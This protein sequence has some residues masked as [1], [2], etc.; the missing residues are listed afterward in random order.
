MAATETPEAT[1]NDFEKRHEKQLGVGQFAKIQS[2][3]ILAPL[4][5]GAIGA[6]I[7]YVTLGK[8]LARMFPGLVRRAKDIDPLA[9]VVIEQTTN[10]RKAV[11]PNA[12]DLINAKWAGAIGLGTVTSLIGSVGVGYDK[13]RKEESAR[14]AANEINK[15]VADLE[16]F[17]P[18]DPELVAENKRLR[19]MLAEAPQTRVHT[20]DARHEGK[21]TT[22]AEHQI[23]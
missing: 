18:S 7:G 11:N 12:G 10:I 20:A 15:D 4:V 16:L 17:R 21:A 9:K 5:T 3:Y 23:G 14:L 2:L 19:A 22:H 13:W 6:G 1:S 8:P